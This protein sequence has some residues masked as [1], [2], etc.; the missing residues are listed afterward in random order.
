MNEL[1]YFLIGLAVIAAGVIS[2]C[3]IKRKRRSEKPPDLPKRRERT[4]YVRTPPRSFRAPVSHVARRSAAPASGPRGVK[5][6]QFPCCPYD[7]QRNLA[8]EKQVI[9]WDSAAGCYCCSRGHR[10]KRNGKIL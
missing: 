2:V 5:P 1:P 8:G 3:L 10:F 4:V 9:F 6:T 7:K